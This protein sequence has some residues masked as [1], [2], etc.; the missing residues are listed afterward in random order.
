MCIQSNNTILY[1]SIL[2]PFAFYGDILIVLME[3]FSTINTIGNNEIKI[4]LTINMC[5]ITVTGLH[6]LLPNHVAES[7]LI[8]EKQ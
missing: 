5:K 4:R 2:R 1:L 8:L 7:G 3:H 6:T